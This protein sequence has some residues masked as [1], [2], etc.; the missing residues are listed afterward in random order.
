[1][2]RTSTVFLAA[3]LFFLA[4]CDESAEVAEA[5]PSP[6]DE[7]AESTEELDTRAGGAEQAGDIVEDRRDDE[8]DDDE[9]DDDEP[10]SPEADYSRRGQVIK[11]TDPSGAEVERV[12]GNLPPAESLAY[13]FEVAAGQSVMVR[14]LGGCTFNGGRVLLADARG[15]RGVGGAVFFRQG[16][17]TASKRYDAT[18]SGLATLTFGSSNEDFSGTFSFEVIDVTNEPVVEI[19]LGDTVAPNAPVQ[20]AGVFEFPGS[21]D[22]Y[23]FDVAAGDAYLIRQLGCE[24]DG[25][26]MATL[27]FEGVGSGTSFMHA[28]S[29]DATT[30]FEAED[31]GAVV[32]YAAAGAGHQGTGTYSFQIVDLNASEAIALEL[33]SVVT[34]D[35]PA[36]GA[37]RIEEPGGRDTYTLQMTAGQTVVLSQQGECDFENGNV[38]LM[39]IRGAGASTNVFFRDGEDEDDCFDVRRFSAETDGLVT[40]RIGSAGNELTGSY[41]FSITASSETVEEAEEVLHELNATEVAEERVITLDETVLFDF[42]SDELKANANRALAAVADVLGVYSDGAVRVV[43]HTDSVGGDEANRRLSERRASAVVAALS[44]LGVAEGRMSAVGRGE[45]APVE[46]NENPVGTDNPEGRAANRR[47][48]VFF[49]ARE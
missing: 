46:A 12:Q 2:R 27:K 9:G 35:V 33:G 30:R 20:G 24:L 1:M 41:T 31:S 22:V 4:G 29:C 42:A 48:E 21:V 26:N 44:G 38:L 13:S 23:R 6:S 5:A 49:S 8:G 40:M 36:R 32:I 37:G 45:S 25:T 47:V 14:Q 10:V 16:D 34:T 19:A 11:V 17:C 7:S 15:P 28:G 39:S 43:G 3:T 18:E